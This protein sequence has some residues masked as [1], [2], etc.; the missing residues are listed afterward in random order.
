MEVLFEPH[1]TSI[2]LQ[3]INHIP[4]VANLESKS[5]LAH[6]LNRL[7]NHFVEE[8][9]FFPRSWSLPWQYDDM[10]A[11]V[12][13][14]P[15]QTFIMKPTRGAEGKGIKLF[16][17]EEEA[18]KLNFGDCVVQLYVPNLLLMDGF[19]FDLRV[20]VI[21]TS[22]DPLRIF[23]YNNGLVR[24]ATFPYAHPHSSNIKNQYMHLTNY[25]INKSSDKYNESPED[26]SK[27]D[28]VAFNAWLAN[29]G[30]DGI[31]L[32]ARIDDIIIKTI[33]CVY[34]ILKDRYEKMFPEQY[35]HSV[36]ACFEMLGM[37]I[38]VDQNM[39]PYL[40]EVNRS[41]SFNI[42]G[43]VDERVK[44]HLLHDTFGLLNLNDYRR[45]AWTQ[46]TNPTDRND[47][48]NKSQDRSKKTYKLVHD[49]KESSLTIKD[50]VKWET[51]NTGN[52]RLIYPTKDSYNYSKFIHHIF[53][54][55]EFSKKKM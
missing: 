40:L 3:R 55:S 9:D 22:I 2:H 23:V 27:R 29:Q 28:F 50:Q 21:V 10:M 24:L 26:G 36:S 8:Y 53:S 42:A 47:T 17:T 12:R 5:F 33:V 54:L 39:K 44:K 48:K 11:Y 37:D 20:Y 18:K 45:G 34:P 35:H 51:R 13:Q 19:K 25:S 14:H 16:S 38:L 4:G 32:W 6:H 7:R 52:F 41:P 31:K 30:L 49:N 46:D 43:V 1:L 15:A